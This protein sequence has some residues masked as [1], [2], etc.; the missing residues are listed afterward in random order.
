MLD[1][2]IPYYNIIMKGD[3][4]VG[5][6]VRLPQ[7]YTL[8][9]YRAGDEADWARMECAVGDFPAREAAAAYFAANF[10]GAQ[11]ALAKR[12]AIAIAPDGTAAGAC[13]A[14][15]E[16]RGEETASFV[17][18]LVVD[19]AH[20]GRGLGRA[21]CAKTLQTFRLLG[22]YEVY[23]HTQPWSYKAVML[24]DSFGFRMLRRGTFLGK[25]NEYAPAMETL[26]GVLPPQ[27]LC[28][29]KAHAQE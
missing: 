24:Y 6:D 20:Q 7:G 13:M 8:R 10:G 3:S 5:A 17:H 22:E 28:R 12:M 4:R 19:P 11:A 15:R 2:T 23:L 14:W 25:E 16:T 9:A 29:L 1:R 18:W 27:A 21:L 26:A